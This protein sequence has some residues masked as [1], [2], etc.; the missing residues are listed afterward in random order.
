MKK[1]TLLCLTMLFS[2][3][4][5]AQ[6]SIGNSS[7]GSGSISSPITN[8][9]GYSY[10][11]SIYLASEVNASGDITSLDFKLNPGASFAEADENVDV[12]IGT[13]TK[14]NFE[15]NTDWVDVSTLTQVLTDGTLTASDDLLHI[16]FNAPFNYNGTDNLIIAVDANEGDYGGSSD[17]VLQ[18]E[19][20]NGDNLS[21]LYRNDNTA[22]DPLDPDAANVV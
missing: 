22:T 8:Y 11:Q 12:W 9:W 4:G 19:A 3:L 7:G 18:T 6:V 2:C 5:F 20:Q 16:E 13:T 15:N 10:G 21:L 17:Y 1:I 14:T